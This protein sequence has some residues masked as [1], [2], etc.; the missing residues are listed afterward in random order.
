MKNLKI[1]AYGGVALAV[2][3][4]FTYIYSVFFKPAGGVNVT[5]LLLIGVALGVLIGY[6]ALRPSLA[7]KQNGVS[8]QSHTI[9]ESMRK[10]FKV[11]CAEGQIQE[12]F[13]YE[14]T[15]KFLNF[16]PATA[17]AIVIVKAKV[18]V[19]FDFEKCKWEA[20]PEQKTIRI[21][22]F[23]DAEILS[24]EPEYNYYSLEDHFLNPI[25]TEHL[26]QIQSQSRKQVEEAALAS[27]LR[28]IAA[29]QMRTLLAEVVAANNWRLENIEQ[30]G[31]S[32]KAVQPALIL[33]EASGR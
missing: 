18:L 4:L 17:K 33:P 8:T 13:N 26:H 28:S 10:V 30:I 7:A 27:G 32:A 9:V 16:I 24:L 2:L 14:E 1:I 11:V 6:L 21:V 15:R 29:S 19:G 20:D 25:K 12:I 31:L 23:P 22:S 3:L 5:G